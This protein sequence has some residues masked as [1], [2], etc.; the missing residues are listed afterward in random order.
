MGDGMFVSDYMTPDPKTVRENDRV[1]LA[2]QI[3]RI[4]NCHQLPVLD[5]SKRLTGIVSD[6]D[7]RSA[8]GYDAKLGDELFVSEIM[9]AAPVSIPLSAS[10]DEAL[11]LLTSNRFNALPVLDDGTLVGI[12][13]RQDLLRAFH[14]ILGLDVKG[15]RV[16]IALPQIREDLC[17]A[18]KA[19][20]SYEGDIVSVIVSSM[21]RDGDEPT[22][23]LRVAGS[24][25]RSIEQALRTAGLIVLVPEHI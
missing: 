23:Y 22:L 14:K 8:V 5:R 18:F 21:R 1:S 17:D 6:R 20:R 13:T 19:I 11:E 24:D 12:I 15:R 2:E 25:P 3:L 7:V 9:T 4:V 16:E 10:F